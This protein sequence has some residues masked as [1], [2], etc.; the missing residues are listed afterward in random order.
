MHPG[1]LLDL[2]TELLKA[3]LRFDQPADAVVSDFFRRH[4]TLGPRE[5]HTLAETT[6]TVLRQRLLLQHLAASNKPAAGSAP[7]RR[8]AML[9]WQGT[10]VYLRGALGPHER[11]WLEEV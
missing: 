10:E 6:Y 11:L 5:R 9:A 4:R 7:E 2:A 8:L 3:V 1:A